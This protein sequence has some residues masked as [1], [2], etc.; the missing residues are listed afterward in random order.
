MEENPIYI[1]ANPIYTY[2]KNNFILYFS[3]FAHR[4][5]PFPMEIQNMMTWICISTWSNFYA[6]HPHLHTILA[7]FIGLHKWYQDLL[8]KPG[9]IRNQSDDSKIL[10]YTLMSK[11]NVIDAVGQLNLMMEGEMTALTSVGE[12]AIALQKA[13]THYSEIVARLEVA[14]RVYAKVTGTV[15]FHEDEYVQF[16]ETYQPMLDELAQ[17]KQQLAFV[18][19]NF[20]HIHPLGAGKQAYVGA[21]HIFQLELNNSFE[22]F[23][24]DVGTPSHDNSL[25]I[26]YCHEFNAVRSRTAS[27]ADCAENY[28]LLNSRF[29]IQVPPAAAQLPLAPQNQPPS[30]QAISGSPPA[31]AG[32]QPQTPVAAALS[33]LAN[34]ASPSP[35]SSTSSSTSS[36][37]SLGKVAL[38]PDSSGSLSSSSSSS[39]EPTPLAYGSNFSVSV[40]RP[41]GSKKKTRSN[42]K[43]STH[44]HKR[45]T[46]KHKRSAHKHKRSAHK[47]S[48][49]KHKHK[50]L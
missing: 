14:E 36:T 1:D 37:S 38:S 50:K 8:L 2:A 45:S 10:F 48:A 12:Q 4:N 43:R 19:T 49:H 31:Q 18:G 30:P 27:F 24:S 22:F 5:E 42:H 44:K 21:F 28:K 32:S 20:A 17:A 15:S 35:T 6:E 13:H 47:R 34:P 29:P 7:E 46:H 25:Y 39:D 11:Q 33:G 3:M 9:P 40:P 26:K 41:G 23:R 16:K